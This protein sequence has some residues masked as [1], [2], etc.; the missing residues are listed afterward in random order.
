MSSHS[1]TKTIGL[2]SLASLL[3]M[4]A[5]VAVLV[6]SWS[7]TAPAGASKVGVKGG[8]AVRNDDFCNPGRV[9]FWT[10]RNYTGTKSAWTACAGSQHFVT[11][12]YSAK[13]RCGI[14]VAIAW[15]EGGGINLK[16]CM[17]PGGDRPDPGRFD[18][19]NANAVSC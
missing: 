17:N 16:A 3:A 13:N 10:G 18:W 15:S 2:V 11:P 5:L 19:I 1:P 14:D 8:S 4:V 6:S 9:C 12:R 7:S